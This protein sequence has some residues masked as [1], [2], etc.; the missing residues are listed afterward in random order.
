MR[1]M[2]K[3]LSLSHVHTKIEGRNNDFRGEGRLLKLKG[4]R[5]KRLKKRGE[6]GGGL[7]RSQGQEIVWEKVSR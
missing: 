5:E 4:N 2:K 3:D 1:K 6:E 7:R